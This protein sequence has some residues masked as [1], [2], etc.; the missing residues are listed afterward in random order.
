MSPLSRR[1]EELA[2][3][4][5]SFLGEKVQLELGE[6][7]RAD[8]LCRIDDGAVATCRIGVCLE[9]DGTGRGVVNLSLG[10][11]VLRSVA[12][13]EFSDALLFLEVCSTGSQS[14][15]T[16]CPGRYGQ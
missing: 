11:M 2:L 1:D 9:G 10:F 8:R 6:R 4:L 14:V 5:K 7:E 15:F 13:I 16:V 3:R 12:R